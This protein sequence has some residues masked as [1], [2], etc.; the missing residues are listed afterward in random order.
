MINK[1]VKPLRQD[2][3]RQD[4]LGVR[5]ATVQGYI[6]IESNQAAVDFSYPTSKLRR[7]RVQQG[8]KVSPTITTTSGVC[9]VKVDD[10]LY[11]DYGVFKLTERE[12]LRLM[13]VKDDDI[14]KMK[15]VNSPTQLYRQAGNS[16][17]VPVLM[18]LFSQLNIKGV[19]PW[20][21]LTQSER[22][23]LIEKNR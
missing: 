1:K 12:C 7:G 14:D 4:K 20:N 5:Q 23:E 22:E 17:I 18:A 10:Y 3:T 15:A 2:K 16:I 6:K 13:G 19:T 21:E 8:G 9:K 11:K